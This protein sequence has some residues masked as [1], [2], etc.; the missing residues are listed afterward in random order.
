MCE[1]ESYIKLIIHFEWGSDEYNR[2]L[3]KRILLAILIYL[4]TLSFPLIK[5][6]SICLIILYLFLF[7]YFSVKRNRRV[8]TPQLNHIS[9]KPSPFPLLSQRDLIDR[10]TFCN[11]TSVKNCKEDFCSCTHVLQVKLKSVVEVILIDEGNFINI[12][13]L[14]VSYNKSL[15]TRKVFNID[16][17]KCTQVG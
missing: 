8:Y 1:V 16:F 17:L 6:F 15:V 3:I 11:E 5:Q 4:I 13:F 7:Y 9:M 2:L 10:N 12:S 14:F